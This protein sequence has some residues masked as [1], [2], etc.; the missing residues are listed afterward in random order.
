MR[1]GVVQDDVQRLA[2]VAADQTLEERQEVGTG[3]PR[4]AFPD[5]LAARDLEGRIQAGQAVAPIVVGLARWQAGP[6]RHSG[7]V[8]LSA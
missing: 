5:D 4:A 1:R 2:A 6:Q 8:R 3:V 7:C